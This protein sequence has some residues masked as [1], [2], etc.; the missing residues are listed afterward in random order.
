[1]SEFDVSSFVASFFDEAKDRL[2][3]IDQHLVA[4]EA[5][6]L[7]EEGLNSLRRDAHTIKGSALMLGVTDVGDMAHLFEDAIEA[8]MS[9][10]EFRT[11]EMVQFLYDVHD[12]LAD[13]LAHPDAQEPLDVS[14]FRTKFDALCEYIAVDSSSDHAAFLA[15]EEV[16]LIGAED[17]EAWR[18]T[19]SEQTDQGVMATQDAM[20]PAVEDIGGFRPDLSKLQMLMPEAKQ[21]SGRF[22]RVDADR[23]DAL[24]NQVM[25]LTMAKS[26]FSSMVEGYEELAHSLRDLRQHW[27]QIRQS[28]EPGGP[29]QVVGLQAMDE[30]FVQYLRRVRR[31]GNEMRYE[32]DR[33]AIALNDIRD[34]ILGLML[35]PLDSIFSTFPRAVRDA[36]VRYHKKVRLQIAGK[37]VEMDQ[38]VAEA[39]VEPLIHLLS[40]AIAHGI[41]TPE[42]RRQAGKPEEGMI[43]ILAEQSGNEVHIEV[44]D[45]G[46]GID[47][48]H[49]R[50][51]AIQRGVTTQ[52]EAQQMDSAE[53]L[54]MIFRPGFSTH[55]DVDDM[56]G[57]GMGMN[58]VQDTVRRLTGS[59]RIHTEKGRGTC[60][61]LSLPVSI[62]VQRSLQ[63]RIG[64]HRF[65]ML[66][67]L[68]EQVLP[69]DRLESLPLDDRERGTAVRHV[70]YE[71]K[72]L[73]LV[74]LRH[75]LERRTDGVSISEPHVIIAKHIEG[76]V[77]IVVDE[78][79]DESEI[80]VRDID[81]YLKRYQMPGLMG[82]SIVSDSQVLLL[83]EPYGIKEM[84]RTA[85]AMAM[86]EQ[87]LA[88]AL[89]TSDAG[90]GARVLLVEDSLIAREVEKKML[91]EAGFAVRT[92]IDGIDALEKA[93][94]ELFELI[95]TD[96]EMPRLDGFGL[97]RQMRNEPNFERMPILVIST[98]D[99]E[100]D[101]LRALDAGADA[102]LVK[103]QLSREG[104]ANTL[105]G[106]LHR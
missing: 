47:I 30:A 53:I 51:V 25:E 79:L 86:Q 36:A 96:L 104:L 4:L 59:V 32:Q 71:G 55:A 7:G 67:H 1:M 6:E 70:R 50:N 27:R 22:L 80:I 57:R 58:V 43:S 41:E 37:S 31:F 13:R 95:V 64:D 29:A 66:T 15:D 76:F 17:A 94:A 65:G 38:G 24:S 89:T 9:H 99:S 68:I 100:E 84:G 46:R 40:N 82:N 88:G 93:R 81:P 12:Q 83:I 42:E 63:F 48:D 14:R 62:T 72:P 35:R 26:R 90:G 75:V 8:L 87:Y 45:D 54:E 78:L 92:A 91:Q 21:A 39:L 69:L 2:A 60:F 74:D 10:P 18:R 33:S 3:L 73:P 106:L 98:R 16:P 20:P 52:H 85:P 56:A 28:L 49:I 101:R 44:L 103:Q 5:G 34:Q 105:H 97:V 11:A 61:S 77:G 23:L 19:E 102:Y